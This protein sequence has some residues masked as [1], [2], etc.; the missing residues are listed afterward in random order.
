MLWHISI[1]TYLLETVCS[2]VNITIYVLYILHIYKILYILHLKKK[3]ASLSNEHKMSYKK[4]VAMNYWQLSSILP[5]SVLECCLEFILRAHS[6]AKESFANKWMINVDEI[7]IY[8]HY[9]S[10][11]S[12]LILEILWLIVLLCNDCTWRHYV[13]LRR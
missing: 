3:T 9:Y 8:W 10:V 11:K 2:L 1:V 7:T 5:S 12:V 4:L 13:F 6:F